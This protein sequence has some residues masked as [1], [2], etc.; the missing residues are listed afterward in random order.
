MAYDVIS[1]DRPENSTIYV[2][3][4]F[5]EV[6][7]TTNFTGAKDTIDLPEGGYIVFLGETGDTMT[8]N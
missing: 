4:K 6:V 3:N 1:V 2:S 8:I 5:L 7:Y